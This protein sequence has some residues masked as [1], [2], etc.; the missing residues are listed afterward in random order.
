[1]KIS[2]LIQESDW[3]SEKHVPVVECPDSVKADKFFEVTVAIGKEVAHPNTTAHHICWI[4]LYFLPEGEKFPCQIGKFA[5]N[6]HGASVKGPDTS[7]VYTHHKVTA[8]MKTSKPGTIIA[9]SLCNIH[10]LWQYSKQI[11]VD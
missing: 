4:S 5:F 7:T 3:K 2:E 8:W 6:S 10:G 9:V 11:K 1:M